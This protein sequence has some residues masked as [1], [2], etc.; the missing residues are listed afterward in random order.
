MSKDKQPEIR[1]PGFTEDWEE[2][3]LDEIFGKIRNAFVGTATPYYV[4]EGHFYLES[5]NVKD[6]RINRNTEVFIND[7]FYEKQKDKW[8]HTNDI[9]MVQSGHV[10][11]TAVIPEDLDKTAAHALIMFSNYKTKTSP[12][13]L[14][15]QFQT[16]TAK[17]KL[18][19]ITTGNTIKHILASEMKKFEVT[20]PEHVEQQKIGSFFK[21]LDDT[22]ALHQRKLDLLKETKKGFLQKMFPKNGAKVPEIRFPGFTEAWEERKLETLFEKG[23]SGGTPKSTNPDYYR[24]N[25]PFLGISDISNSN[26]YI[27]KTEKSITL[28]GLNNSAA[29]VVPKGAISLAMYASVG[30]LA[31]LNIDVATSQ[32][33]YNMVF[34]DDRL[35]DFVY[36][37]LS[38]ANDLG[39][40]IKLISTGTQANLN[41]DKVKNFVI[42]LPSNIEEIGKIGSF[43][44]QIDNTIILHQRKLDLLKETKKGFLQKMFV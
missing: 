8:L 39:E 25:I 23:G 13:F 9:V 18:E 15:Y 19:N 4:D 21:Q 24:G 11:H 12:F 10:G 44:N 28:E 17:R 20:I 32:A 34:N 30:K 29:W 1:F 16:L 38:M 3:K 33:F 31:I 6:G 36:Q 7:E 27:K 14:N 37:R 42:Q 26:G 40:W 2:R 41:A 43:L 5:N 35:R 22:I